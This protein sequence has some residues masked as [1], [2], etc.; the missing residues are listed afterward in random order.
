MILP[1][2]LSRQ[3]AKSFEPSSG[4]AVTQIWSPHTTGLDQPLSCSGV[5]HFTFCVSLH[6]VGTLVASDV[7]SPLGPRNC[8]QLSAAH[9][10]ATESIQSINA[11]KNGRN[12]LRSLS[13]SID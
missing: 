4:A 11:I 8:G 1:V 3:M 6:V 2:F 12:M 7:P 13:S 5:F 10:A 9:T